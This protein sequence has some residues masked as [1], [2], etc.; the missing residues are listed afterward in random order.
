MRNRDMDNHQKAYVCIHVFDGT[1]PV[2][3]VSRN[4]GDW[5]FLCGA[6]HEQ[7]PSNV[8]VV[9]IGHLFARDPSLL[10]LEDLQADWEAERASPKDNWRRAKIV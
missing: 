3:L 8:R 1:S 2:L 10:E 7:D 6:E 4:D 9:G 5:S